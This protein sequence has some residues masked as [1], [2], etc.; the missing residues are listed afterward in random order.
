MGLFSGTGNLIAQSS[1]PGAS[2]GPGAI[3]SDTDA[4]ITYR[5]NDAN[6]A[7]VQMVPVI[8]SSVSASAA[9]A[10]S[11]LDGLLWEALGDYEAATAENSHTF[12]FTA[13]D[14]DDD[15]MLVLVIDVVATASF[16]LGMRLN[17]DATANYYNDGRQIIGGTETLLDINAQNE[18]EIADANLITVGNENTFAIIQLALHKGGTLDRGTMHAMVSTGSGQR[19]VDGFFDVNTSSLTDVEVLTSTSTWKTGSRITLYKVP[20]A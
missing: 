10:S 5:R 13:V 4:D 11:K 2:A 8:N 14:F 16:I 6:S 1:D 15:S 12:S 9:I 20:R 3:W 17:T 7:W 19:V 18:W